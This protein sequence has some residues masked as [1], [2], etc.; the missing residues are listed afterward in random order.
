MFTVLD[1]ISWPGHP[2]KPNEDICGVSDD[3]AWV[4][5]TSIFPGTSP[6]IHDK[7]DAAW[8]AQFANERLSGLAP[9]AEDGVTLLRHVMEEARIAYRAVAPAER[10]EDFITWPLG[11]MTLVRR[12]GNALDAWTFGDTTAYLRQPDGSVQVLGDAPGLREAEASK[13]AE[14]MRQSGSR[15][16]AILDEPVFLEWLGER[17]ERQRKSG[18][19]AALLS[20]N[21]DAVARLR[22]ETA[23]CADG[24]VILLASD[25]FSALVDLY[26]AMDAK[27][28]VDEAL[29]TGLEPLAKLAREIE[30]DR[31]PDGKLFPRFKASDDTTALLLRA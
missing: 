5:D 27:A 21:P 7:S 19:P 20:F 23:P 18:V 3:W 4:I 22:H 16:T 13:A 1:R 9:Q 8:L 17:R 25:G 26:R 28:L 29:A 6:V 30:T 14:L 15:P 2:D 31:D 11:A 10:H 12:K 24:T